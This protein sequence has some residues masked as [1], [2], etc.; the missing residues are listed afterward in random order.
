MNKESD[1]IVVI[2]RR[3]CIKGRVFPIIVIYNEKECEVYG[4]NGKGNCGN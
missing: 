3:G 1:G 2:F 4:I